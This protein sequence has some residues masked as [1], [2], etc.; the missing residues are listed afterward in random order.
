MNQLKLRVAVLEQGILDKEHVVKQLQLR[1]AGL[2]QGISEK[3]HLV[4]QTKEML[5]ATQQQKV[6]KLLLCPH[7][8]GA[9]S[10]MQIPKLFLANHDLRHH[11]SLQECQD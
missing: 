1:V 8:C 6:S 7:Y 11:L 9:T 3:E 5:K 2:E 4:G 10:A